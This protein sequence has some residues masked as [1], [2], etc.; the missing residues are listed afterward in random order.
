MAGMSCPAAVERVIEV[1]FNEEVMGWEVSF[2]K[3]RSRDD[4]F[5]C[6]GNEVGLVGVN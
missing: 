3:S 1:S 2:A 5:S 4:I 6:F